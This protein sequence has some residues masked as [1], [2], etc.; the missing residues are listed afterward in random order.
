[1][2]ANQQ[3]GLLI[4]V[5]ILFLAS[6]GIA[7]SDDV[8]LGKTAEMV[9]LLQTALGCTGSLNE[10]LRGPVSDSVSLCCGSIGGHMS[11]L[12]A[13]LS[14]VCSWFVILCGLFH[15]THTR[16]HTCTKQECVLTRSVC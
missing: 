8:G 5:L 13:C 9:E 3:R 11:S 1:M 4:S 7:Q 2:G 14:Q 6:A 12:S 10:C 16:A 15:L